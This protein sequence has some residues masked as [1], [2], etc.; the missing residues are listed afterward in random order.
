MVRRPVVVIDD[1]PLVSTALV[2]ALRAERIDAA[3]IPVT[4]RAAILAA[5]GA[6]PPG[7]ALLDLDLGDT[8]GLELIG[9]LRDGGWA[10]LVVTACQDRRPIAAAVSRGAIGWVGKREPFER[11]VAVVADA[12]AGREVLAPAIRD[13]LV[14]LHQSAHLRHEQL[15]RGLA[16]LSARERLVLTRLAAGHAAADVAAEFAVSLTTVRAQIRS[17]LAKLDVRSQLA[18][19]A[20]LNE[21]GRAGLG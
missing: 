14:R 11:L 4:D 9:P 12:A 19:V 21:A 10:V 5:V 8:S 2:V 6:H 20:V 7:L 13:E 18:A 3:R 16:R 17:I 15:R 1:H